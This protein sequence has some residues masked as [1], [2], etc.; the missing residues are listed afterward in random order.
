MREFL[1]ATE[2]E[3]LVSI[4][5]ADAKRWEMVHGADS[6]CRADNR[7]A[8]HSGGA[9][10]L[11]Q[12]QGKPWPRLR[13]AVLIAGALGTLFWAGSIVWW[14]RIPTNH[15]D[16]FELMGAFLSTGLF[17]VLVLP[18]I[19]LGVMGRWLGFAAV[20]GVLV[21]IIVSDTLLPWFPWNWLPGPA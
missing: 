8:V 7:R 2:N 14:W 21:L 15:R 4:F 13:V 3:R 10:K 19:I 1:L 12:S 9:T 18:T 16:G 17:L 5:N 20:L 11:V 6:G